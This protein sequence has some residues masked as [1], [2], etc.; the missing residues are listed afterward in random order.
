MANPSG[1]PAIVVEPEDIP[2]RTIRFQCGLLREEESFTGPDARYLC[3]D[4]L[5]DYACDLLNTK[6]SL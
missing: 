1:I 2:K 4:Q 5:V 6:V 3:R